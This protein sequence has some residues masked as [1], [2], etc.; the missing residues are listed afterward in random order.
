MCLNSYKSTYEVVEINILRKILKI[1]STY[2]GAPKTST[3][4]RHK[5]EEMKK[6]KK[7]CP[8]SIQ[9]CFYL[10]YKVKPRFSNFKAE[11]HSRASLH[12]SP[13]HSIIFLSFFNY[14]TQIQSYTNTHT[15]IYYLSSTILKQ[16]EQRKSSKQMKK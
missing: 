3:N 7:Y 4:I 12:F 15:Y 8:Y 10:T 14:I 2:K 6:Q 9:Y 1:K 13:F 16:R 5:K 11:I